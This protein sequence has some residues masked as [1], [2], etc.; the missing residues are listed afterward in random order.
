MELAEFYRFS[1]FGLSEDELLALEYHRPRLAAAR[2]LERA[3][4]GE[5]LLTAAGWFDLTLAA[6]GDRDLAERA[7]NDYVRRKLK[8]SEIPE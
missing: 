2:D 5:L 6:T 8:A 3:R 4:R 1:T 7:H